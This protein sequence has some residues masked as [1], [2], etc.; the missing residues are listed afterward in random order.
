MS[1]RDSTISNNR[2]SSQFNFDFRRDSSIFNEQRASTA[3]TFSKT[4]E[5]KVVLITGATGGIGRATSVAF[6]RTG[7]YDLALHFY[8][9]DEDSQHR[10]LLA[11]NDAVNAVIDVALYQ[12]DLSTFDGVRK[13]HREVCEQFGGV[14]VLFAN[15]GGSGGVTSPA[16]LADVDMEAFERAWRLNA[17]G[18]MLLTQLCLPHM[19][20]KRWGRVVLCSSVAAWSGG[21]VGPHYASSKSALH[22][23]VFWLARNVAAKGITVNG[24]APALIDGTAMM[25]GLEGEVKGKMAQ[26][27]PV[28]R[29]GNPDEIASTVMWMVDTGYVT[30][31][32]IGVDGGA[33]PY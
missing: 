10:L 12:A 24:V 14:D 15:A 28:G 3:S 13:L 25:G 33:H 6:A 17:A 4:G 20:T 30:R 2:V 23:F 5:R 7:K 8:T 16:G 11:I 1:A 26:N 32:I 22:G 19:E 9:A 18:P 29:L 27:I 31:K 21:V